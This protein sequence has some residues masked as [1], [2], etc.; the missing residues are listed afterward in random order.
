MHSYFNRTVSLKALRFKYPIRRNQLH[1]EFPLWVTIFQRSHYLWQQEKLVTL[2]LIQAGQAGE[3]NQ[4]S[5]TGVN[6]KNWVA[7]NGTLCCFNLRVLAC[8]V[9]DSKQVGHLLRFLLLQLRAHKVDPSFKRKGRVSRSWVEGVRTRK[10]YNPAFCVSYH[11]WCHETLIRRYCARIIFL[12]G[13]WYWCK[14]WDFE[15][16]N[17]WLGFYPRSVCPTPQPIFFLLSHTTWS[18]R[19]REKQLQGPFQWGLR[20]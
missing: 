11:I 9:W 18:I 8:R 12:E 3:E 7:S 1:T 13:V 6:P 19:E 5:S 14:V 10:L 2:P 17:D 4:V 20:G 16:H 15:R